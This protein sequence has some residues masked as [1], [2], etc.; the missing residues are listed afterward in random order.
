[1]I[2]RKDYIHVISKLGFA[3]FIGGAIEIARQFPDS[4][5]LMLVVGG[6]MVALALEEDED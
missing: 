2:T 4:A 5:M 6:L 3:L 1:M